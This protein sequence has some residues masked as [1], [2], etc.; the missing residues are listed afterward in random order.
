MPLI[1]LR[2]ALFH[3]LFYVHCTTWFVL[4][5]LAWPLPGGAM[6]RFARWWSAGSVLLHEM[7]T[8]ARVEIRGIDNIPPGPLL[9][10]AK[11]QSAWETMA[12]VLFFPKPS[13]I[14]KRELLWVPLFG[15]HLMKA[16]Q[17]PIDR[18]D[19]QKALSAI[20][21]GTRRA[22]RRGRQ[23]MIFPEGTRR[24]VGAPPSYRFGVAKIY[25][26][27]GDQPCIPVAVVS[28]LAWP[29]NTLL[30]YPRPIIVEFLPTIPGGL[31]PDEFFERMKASIEA[32][33]ERLQAEAGYRPDKAGFNQSSA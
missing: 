5:M 16:D 33:N 22:V 28:G 31:D 19:R 11:H 26:A 12:L 17:I 3:A 1:Y 20:A 4:A 8:G 15:W 27:L 9:V 30:H 2:S 25:E 6:L 14:L 21:E 32:A 13:Y 10:A 18:G 7:V 29:R 23:I 24:K